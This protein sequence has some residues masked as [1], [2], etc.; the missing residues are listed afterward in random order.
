MSLTLSYFSFF[1]ALTVFSLFLLWCFSLLRVSLCSRTNVSSF[2]FGLYIF[3]VSLICLFS[4]IGEGLSDAS[5]SLLFILSCFLSFSMSLHCLLCAIVSS[6]RV[7][8]LLHH[9][10]IYIFSFLLSICF[11]VL[12]KVTSFIDCCLDFCYA[13]F[14]PLLLLPP[15]LLP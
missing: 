7:L 14:V 4:C 8:F 9:W 15:L 11:L 10:F 1:L 6:F 5:F 2:R 3:F 13:I 12:T